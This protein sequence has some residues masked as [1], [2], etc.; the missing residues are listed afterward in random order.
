MEIFQ[1][2]NFYQIFDKNFFFY[3]SQ[4]KDQVSIENDVND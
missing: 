2:K 3:V 4:I 1:K